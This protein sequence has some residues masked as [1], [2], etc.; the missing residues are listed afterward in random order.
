VQRLEGY[1]MGLT[2]KFFEKMLDGVIGLIVKKHSDDIFLVDEVQ[3]LIE[4]MHKHYLDC[5]RKYDEIISE[6][7]NNFIYPHPVLIEIRKDSV[8]GIIDRDKL[9]GLTRHKTDNNEVDN[10][11]RSIAHYMCQAIEAPDPRSNAQ[12]SG[13]MGSLAKTLDQ[14]AITRYLAI[15]GPRDLSQER[16]LSLYANSARPY[17]ERE[18]TKNLTKSEQ[19]R[20]FKDV[21]KFLEAG[22]KP[23]KSSGRITIS[24]QPA[25]T[26]EQI[27]TCQRLIRAATD[28]QRR[29]FEEVC[30][31]YAQAKSS[32]V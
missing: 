16:F 4:G 6:D 20:M 29:S 8:F 27:E 23:S 19:S 22:Q 1:A 9:N 26:T 5:Y 12:R 18:L 7:K 31:N 14:E 15:E 24:A 21:R 17:T 32:L 10:Y 3:K 28:W 25:F 2:E 11:L 30:T 13:L